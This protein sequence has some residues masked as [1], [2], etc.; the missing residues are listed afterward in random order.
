MIL[1]IHDWGN[2]TKLAPHVEQGKTKKQSR[3]QTLINPIMN[4]RS[5]AN[6]TSAPA[7]LLDDYI[8]DIN[9]LSGETFTTKMVRRSEEDE[10]I[11]HLSTVRII[12]A[13]IAGHYEHK[14]LDKFIEENNV[15]IAKCYSKYGDDGYFCGAT[16]DVISEI[17]R[18]KPEHQTLIYNNNILEQKRIIHGTRSLHENDCI[19]VVFTA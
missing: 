3:H 10:H 7:P 13:R 18:Y 12:K 17:K 6:E 1:D 19:T 11:E 4:E 14:L 15:I 8:L 9:T 5:K 16:E 2:N